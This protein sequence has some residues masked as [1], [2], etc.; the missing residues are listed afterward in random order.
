[1]KKSFFFFLYIDF[2]SNPYILE[3]A[4]MLCKWKEYLWSEN[5]VTIVLY[6]TSRTFGYPNCC[7][8]QPNEEEDNYHHDTGDH[9]WTNGESSHGKLLKFG[10]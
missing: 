1:M 9:K 2:S 5:Y 6:Q 3:L 10:S 8:K 4:F 7:H